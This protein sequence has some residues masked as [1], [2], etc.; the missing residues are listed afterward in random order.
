MEIAKKK[1]VAGIALVVALLAIAAGLFFGGKKTTDVFNEPPSDGL[2]KITILESAHGSLTANKYEA[3]EGEEI[4][5]T[6]TPDENYELT[7]L[8]VNQKAS[9][10]TFKMPAEDVK[11]LA[12]FALIAGTESADAYEGDTFGVAEGY[13]TTEGVDLLND[14]G[15]Q[16]FISVIAGGP[17]YA[18]VKNVYTDK[19]VF[20]TTFKVKEI[21]NE[22]AF[23]KFGIVLNGT[24][25]MVKFFVDMKPDMTC[26]GVGVV[27]QPTGG[28]DDWAN[29]YSK[30]IDKIDLSKDE[31]TLKVVRD[32]QDY[33]FY[34]NG[35]MV[36]CE[37]GAICN[38]NTAVGI[39][40][41]NTGLDAHGYRHV[42]DGAAKT[43]IE[44]AK[45]DSYPLIGDFFGKSGKYLSSDV[46]DFSTDHGE[47][48]YLVLDAGV[49]TPL[50]TYINDFA[51]KQYYFE[52][53]ATVTDIRDDE[54]FPKF[55]I[56][57]RNDKEMVKFYL[58][59]SR[60]KLVSQV[61]VVRQPEGGKD[62]WN[63]QDVAL[64]S[65]KPDLGKAKVEIGVLR[66]GTAYYIYVNDELVYR[67]NDLSSREEAAGFFSFGTSLI[68]NNYKLVEAGED[69]DA[70]LKK[71]KKDS[72]ELY[73]FKLSQN[74]FDE[75]EN[76][77]YALT[78]TSADEGKVD[79]VMRYAEV[80]RDD[81][82]SISGKITLL[83]A[84]TWSQARILIS[85]D[86]KNEHVIA[87]EKTGNGSYQ[88]I[89][90]SKNDEKA[91]DDWRLISSAG[92]N[93]DNR[94]IDFEVIVDGRKVY[95]LIDDE[96][97]YTSDRVNMVESTVK[98]A[99]YKS[100]TTRVENLTGK[101]FEDS[102][103][104]NEYLKTKDYAKFETERE[105]RINELYKEYFVTNDCA[106]NGGTLLLGQSHL[107][108][109]GDWEAQT[110]L[111]NYVNGYNIAM[112]L[113]TTDDWL[114]AYDKLVKP[115]KEGGLDNIVIAL[116]ENDATN[117]GKSGAEI[118]EN[119]KKLFEK[120][121]ADFPNAEISYIYQIPS[122]ANYEKGKFTNEKQADL[123][124][125][126]KQLVASLDYVTGIDLF[127]KLVTANKKNSNKELFR[128]DKLHMNEKGYEILGNILYEKITKGETFGMVEGEG[129]TYKTTSGV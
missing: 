47:A 15:D 89:A 38:E 83:N 17:Q 81:Y 43:E 13:L 117:W 110:G 24:T 18:Y 37:K 57:A 65:K 125:A 48:P 107:A 77:V 126:E 121:H 113:S 87:L 9:E 124:K 102:Q 80:F 26:E 86:P 84:K 120:L 90:M 98:F 42:E 74:F 105:T 104:L 46:I 32:G 3:K 63:N 49:S 79:D 27:H 118:V 55:G 60:E 76:G 58:D 64:L 66:N 114:Y 112:D 127:D 71:A 94:S 73:E 68:I 91:W 53:D 88:I 119:L 28:E 51:S 23:P 11:V 61:G 20:E 85:S 106:G 52:V 5:L 14:N 16:P 62:D 116:G 122:P 40:S 103:K 44:Q 41:F 45:L 128:D 30:G 70:L 129:V 33:Y 2:Y 59:M 56:I 36:L 19:L 25:E 31:I 72:K 93:G 50:Y 21:F 1:I 69:F 54:K 99:G 109:W 82:Y 39:F 12:K 100:G 10:T 8:S 4:V 101:T 123:A 108:L 111:T 115:F 29:A 35:V 96:I 34:V 67:G 75:I 92:L 97:C 78:A 6:V 95:F 7:S 22:D